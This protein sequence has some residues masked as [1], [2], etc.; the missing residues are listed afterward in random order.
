MDSH[1][2]EKDVNILKILKLKYSDIMNKIAIIRVSILGILLSSVAVV[3]SFISPS[4]RKS[5]KVAFVFNGNC[6]VQ[7][8]DNTPITCTRPMTGALQTCDRTGI[9]QCGTLPLFTLNCTA[10][11]TATDGQPLE[12]EGC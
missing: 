7:D 4:K 1:L 12:G 9:G 6:K 10:L 3:L 8:T 11:T 5:E 2:T